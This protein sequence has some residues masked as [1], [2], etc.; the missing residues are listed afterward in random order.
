MEKKITLQ[1]VLNLTPKHVKI[2][3]FDEFGSIEEKDWSKYRT[4]YVE[5]MGAT[6]DDYDKPERGCLSICIATPKVTPLSF[7]T[8]TMI[9]VM[10]QFLYYI[11]DGN[12]KD[13]M[14][15][16]EIFCNLCEFWSNSEYTIDRYG[17]WY[18]ED[19][20]KIA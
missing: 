14:S 17:N 12:F 11:L 3:V 18:D 20:E 9:K 2:M 13:D 19:G 8:P 7:S 15:Y 10:H 6:L 4:S 1:D 16:N 5:S